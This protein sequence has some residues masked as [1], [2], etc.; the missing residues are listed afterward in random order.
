MVTVRS[1]AQVHVIAEFDAMR[2]VGMRVPDVAYEFVNNHMP[3][4]EEYVNDLGVADA[5]D[6]LIQLAECR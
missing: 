2:S 5:A 1:Q 4:V 6:L 3:D